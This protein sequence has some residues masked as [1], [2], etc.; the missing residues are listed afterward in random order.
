[1]TRRD[2]PLEASG[3]T[4]TAISAALAANASEV[5]RPSRSAESFDIADPL[6]VNERMHRINETLD[7]VMIASGIL[8]SE[9]AGRE[10][11][12]AEID[13]NNIVRD[14][15]FDAAFL[16]ARL[17]PCLGGWYS[18]RAAKT[19]TNK[20]V[21]TATMEIARQ[22]KKAVDVALL[23]GAMGTSF[24]SVYLG[25][26]KIA[27]NRAAPNPIAVVDRLTPAKTGGFFG[28]AERPIS[29]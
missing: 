10:K 1:M 20:I 2:L 4:G 16:T 14:E 19:V 7:N 25:H 24:R 17:G 23:R 26:L 12:H 8:V 3:R 18:Y 6:K 27:P 11:L 15:R 13:A 22:L 21:R 9:G 29:W 5:T 28:W